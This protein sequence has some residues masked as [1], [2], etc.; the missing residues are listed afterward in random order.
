MLDDFVLHSFSSCYGHD[1]RQEDI[2]ESDVRP[3]VDVVY[4]GSVGSLLSAHF[5]FLEA[6]CMV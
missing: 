3:L 1:S 5:S 2:F 6:K 4:S